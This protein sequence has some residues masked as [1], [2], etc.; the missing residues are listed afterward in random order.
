MFI[1]GKLTKKKKSSTSQK[2]IWGDN[3][4]LTFDLMSSDSEEAAFMLVL[5]SKLESSVSPSSP[6]TPGTP[7]NHNNDS[8]KDRHIGHF[9]IG[10][11]FWIEMRQQP[12]KQILKW[13]K[14]Y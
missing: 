14:L 4:T 7:D 9:I 10:K 5:S 8:R 13:H 12:R 6:E 2:M 1:N 3:E 11:E